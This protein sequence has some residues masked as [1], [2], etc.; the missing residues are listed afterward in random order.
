MAEA[1]LNR[2]YL[3]VGLPRSGK[4]TWALK[5]GYPIVS[6]DAISL[7]THGQR[8]WAPAERTVW[9]MAWQMVAALFHAGHRAVIVDACHLTQER[10]DFWD[11]PDMGDH[12][13]WPVWKLCLHVVDTSETV[14]LERANA[15][16]DIIPVI[17][18]MASG[19]EWPTS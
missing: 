8:F 16:Y 15:D 3:T 17:R 12:P 1:Y 2:L 14:C 7:A 9:A 13:D 5:Q 11:S 6:P 4:T 19:A 10:R 18:R